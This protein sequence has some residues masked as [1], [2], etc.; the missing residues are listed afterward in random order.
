MSVKGLAA[1]LAL[2]AAPALQRQVTFRGAL[3]RVN[4]AMRGRAAGIALLSALIAVRML[5]PVAIERLR[6][7]QFDT[8]QQI[9]PRDT[10][11][12]PVAVLDIDEDSLRRIG[13]WPWPRNVIARLVERLTELGAA[14]IG[15]DV[16]FPELDRMS[17]A[18]F[19]KTT[20]GLSPQ[21]QNELAGRP[22]NDEILARAIANNRV[23][24]G[25]ASQD[26]SK[27]DPPA[28]RTTAVVEI[29]GDPRPFL[30]NYPALVGN[31]P[32][33]ESA[34]QGRG[35]FFLLPESDGVIR[36]VPTVIRVGQDLV[37]ALFVELLRVAT[38]QPSYA[39]RS[40][41]AGLEGLIIARVTIPTDRDGTFW[42]RYAR[43]RPDRLLPAADV[44]DGSVDPKSVSGK[45]VLIGTSAAGLGDIRV[46]PLGY[47]MPGVEIQAQILETAIAGAG[48]RRPVW[49]QALEIAAVIVAGLLLI[50]LVPL[51]GARWTIGLL[52]GM[53]GLFAGTAWY[54]FVEQSLLFDAVY[55]SA[56]TLLC[57][58]LLVY[59]GH[60]TVERQRRQVSE[61]FGR[62]LSPVLVQRL[63]K[64]PD[65][66][67]LGGELKHMTILFCDIRGFTRI[68]ERLQNKPET[69][70]N[71]VNR[72]LTPLSEEVLKHNGTIDKYIGDCIMAFWNAPLDDGAHAANACRAA[73]D[74]FKA[75]AALNAELRTEANQSDNARQIARAF[76]DLKQLPM[77]P[78]SDGDRQ[79]LIGVL[80]R[81]AS[82]G[83]AFAQY[84][85]AK[86][87]RDGLVGRKDL[88]RAVQ[89][90]SSAAESGYT[91]A[92]CN[93]GSRYARGDGVPH[94]RVMALT[95]LTL[96]ARDGLAAAEE[97]RV[98]LL[99]HMKADEISESERRVQAWRPS[100]S[101]QAI[102]QINMGIGINTGPC[103]VGNMGSRVRFDYSV[104]GD[105]VNLA[106][107]LEAQSSNYGVPI[108]ISAATRREVEDFA[109]LEL[110]RIIV[111]GKTEQVAIFGLIG[112]PDMAT[113]AEFQQLKKA[114]E[115][116]LDAYR[117]RRW[118][119]AL[120]CLSGCLS[121]AVQLEGLYDLYR[122][123]VESFL[124]SPPPLDWDGVFVALKK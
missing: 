30:Y 53:V 37:P 58:S 124:E 21:S 119:E 13:Q 46:T 97:S 23:V 11:I 106:S 32:P 43:P 39:I 19:V 40:S 45:L 68:S 2:R 56:S 73:L 109:T 59:V 62:Y 51:L 80:Q 16:V 27:V 114:H 76:R 107:R 74:M 4:A 35:G 122:E 28:F 120:D 63:A 91:P 105:T 118:R 17:P 34:A 83:S 9:A 86:A 85:L 64:D 77:S 117:A 24:L 36:R 33:L 1:T 20:E 93:L 113:T 44:L 84:S 79:E 65:R 87:Y 100:R 60:Y 50:A 90:F 49:I 18:E 75:L 47:S 102:T 52:V 67:K 101:G 110:D 55:P 5:D 6:F 12:S 115:A 72:F 96:A 25:I 112:G 92:Q 22:S 42:I 88:G 111:K 81:E 99:R 54:A 31:V 57:Y 82:Q 69:L 108:V 78:E 14:S 26:R 98:E 94:D 29:G 104:L 89:L 41:Q 71:L 3:K 116:M 95:W 10:T 123:R 61:A 7:Q 48:L 103:V 70:T 8:M 121:M 38:G 66:L 15:F